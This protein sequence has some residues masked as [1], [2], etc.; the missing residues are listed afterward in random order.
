MLWQHDGTILADLRWN[1]VSLPAKA[2]LYF[3]PIHTGAIYGWP[4]KII[5]VLI[6]IGMSISGRALVVVAQTQG[7]IAYA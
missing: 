4:T 1:M 6:L 7:Q 5:A 3:Y 2:A